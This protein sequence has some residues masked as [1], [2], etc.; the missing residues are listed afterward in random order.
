[1]V[2][3]ESTIVDFGDR[4]RAVRE[5]RQLSQTDLCQRAALGNATLSIIE[6]QRRVPSVQNVIKVCKALEVS[7]DYMLGLSED[8]QPNGPLTSRMIRGWSQLSTKEQEILVKMCEVILAERVETAP[9]E[10]HLREF[11]VG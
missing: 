4:C 11:A 7:A 1:M 10:R 3:E 6:N 5:L 9:R 8:F 2:S